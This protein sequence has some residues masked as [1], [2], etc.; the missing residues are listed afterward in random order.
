MRVPD[1]PRAVAELNALRQAGDPT[2]RAAAERLADAL[3]DAPH[4][5][6][7]YGSLVPGGTNAD[8]LDGLRGAW[9]PGWVT[10]A[11]A[12]AGWGAAIGYPALCWSPDADT[13]VPA[14]LFTSPDL[15]DHWSRLDAFEGDEYCRILA[16]IFDD[17]GLLGV[18]YV[19]ER[20]APRSG[21]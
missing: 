12:H 21:P 19:Y 7:A 11:L 16:P 9:R 10:G 4:H 1:V 13:R 6:I 3:F 8:Q 17:G 2:L 18:G 20:A 14:Q 15:P 5:L